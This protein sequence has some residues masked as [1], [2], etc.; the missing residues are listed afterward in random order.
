[1]GTAPPASYIQNMRS[2]KPR[3]DK[4]HGFTLLELSFV[5][6]VIA[7]LLMMI[8]GITDSMRA[9]AEKS[10]CMGNLRGLYSGAACYVMD[11]GHWPQISPSLL[12][13]DSKD[14][15][16]LWI[17]ALSPYGLSQQNWIC[18]TQQRSLGDPDLTKKEAA[19]VDYNATP[20]DDRPHTP[21]LWPTQPWFV[22]HAAEH[23]G[24]PLLIYTSGR[25]VTLEEAVRNR[26]ISP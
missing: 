11:Q 24:G 15:A 13:G 14:Y 1:M 9:R 19:R 2:L 26:S 18:P 23:D 4:D 16:N 3:R 10:K 8:V 22:E 12:A 5:V 20:F 17:Q 6:L 7:I 25:V 21:Y